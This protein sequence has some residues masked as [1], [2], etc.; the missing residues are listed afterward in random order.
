MSHIDQ[1][2]WLAFLDGT[3]PAAERA[4][5]AAHLLEPCEACEELL[6]TMHERAEVDRLDGLVDEALLGAAKAERADPPDDLGFSKVVAELRGP[7]K[8]SRVL[9]WL[10]LAAAAGLA[11]VLLL[12]PGP[13]RLKGEASAPARLRLELLRAEPGARENVT[14]LG[15]RGHAKVGDVLVFR[16]RLA[17]AGCLRLYAGADQSAR[18]IDD[19]PTCLPPGEHVLSSSGVVL[20]WPVKEQGRLLLRAEAE[21]ESGARISDEV[22][23]NVP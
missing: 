23:V 2:T 13:E 5:V 16:V 14:P 11:S 15:D 6:A 19:A 7:K 1:P 4:R 8:R 9:T 10:P 18:P 21:L 20:G 22:E 3:L 17:E 12:R